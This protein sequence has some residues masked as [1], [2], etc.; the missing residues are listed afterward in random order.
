MLSKALRLRYRG[1]SH[2]IRFQS[3]FNSNHTKKQLQQLHELPGVIFVIGGPGC[4]K[5]TQCQLISQSYDDIQHISAGDLLRNEIKTGSKNGKLI[6]NILDKGK[7]VPVSITLDLLKKQM[8]VLN[9]K[10]YLID[11]F[12]RNE[13]NLSG[14]N[15]SHMENFC[16]VECCLYFEVSNNEIQRRLLNRGKTSGR[17][18][19][20]LTTVQRRIA[21]HNEVTKHIVNYFDDKSL[22]KR[23]NGEQSV[24]DVQRDV[25]NV[26]APL[27]EKRENE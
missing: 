12:P 7:I 22:L 23:I 27:L 17:S 3:L 18:D 14:W 16:R 24:N 21:T 20:N 6:A 2:R 15:D 4:G 11:G 8:L 10:R 9:S 5:G 26:I 13:D 1:I 25:N 19:D